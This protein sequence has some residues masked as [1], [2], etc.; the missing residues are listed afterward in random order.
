MFFLWEYC[1]N[2]RICERCIG[3]Y[4]K[5]YVRVSS[6]CY[7]LGS[8]MR[9]RDGSSVKELGAR[10]AVGGPEHTGIQSVAGVYS[11]YTWQRER[12]GD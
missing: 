10:M 12:Q 2:K 8:R 4:G 5:H 1:K 3:Q 6:D 9:E 11:V 7:V